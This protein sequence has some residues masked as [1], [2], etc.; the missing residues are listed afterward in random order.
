M[1]KSV[2]FSKQVTTYFYKTINNLFFQKK[3][4]QMKR[5]LLLSLTSIML[6]FSACKNEGPI[7][8]PE[9]SKSQKPAKVQPKWIGLPQNASNKLFKTFST[10]QLI[11]VASGGQ[12]T[13]DETYTSTEGNQVHAYSNI[14]LDP[15]CVQQDCTISMDIDDQTG[16]STFLPHQMFNF[17]AILNQTFT[18]LNL[19]GIDVSNIHLYYLETD[20]SY[21]IMECDQL[22][23][24]VATGTITVVNG[25]LPHF[26]LYGYGI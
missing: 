24:D 20:G 23:V 5:L 21:Q 14:V 16:V 1:E 4:E 13:I 2:V 12:L 6:I 22:T 11:T 10:S 19:S 8:S 17:P 18:G 26:S 15:G 7:T 25:K 3:G 9:P